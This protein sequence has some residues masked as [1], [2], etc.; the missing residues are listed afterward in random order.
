MTTNLEIRIPTYLD[1]ENNSDKSSTLDKEERL[2]EEN[3]VLKK[4][5]ETKDHKIQDLERAIT[6]IN[7]CGEI[8]SL[9]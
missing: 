7:N 6:E 9:V 2:T 1:E 5:I 3:E 8:Y 4:L